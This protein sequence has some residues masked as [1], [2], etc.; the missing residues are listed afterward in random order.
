MQDL[1]RILLLVLRD[2]VE[3]RSASLPINLL[4]WQECS[5]SMQAQKARALSDSAMHLIFLSLFSKMFPD[6]YPARS[7]SG[8][9]LF[10]MEQNCFTHLP[11]RPFR[12]LRSSNARRM[13]ER[14][15]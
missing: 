9:A 5:I 2:S 12:K 1:R 7:R 6:F 10:V 3:N 4:Q 11:K 14:M 8:A 13:A 15:M